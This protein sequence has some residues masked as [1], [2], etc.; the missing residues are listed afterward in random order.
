M[1][2][3][4]FS[5]RKEITLILVIKGVLIFMLWFFFFQHPLA[6]HLNV[7]DVASHIVS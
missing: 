7:Q 6:D 1:A 2:K 4:S 3:L 5:L